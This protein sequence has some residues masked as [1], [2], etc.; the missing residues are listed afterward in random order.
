[1][2]PTDLTVGQLIDIFINR[3]PIPDDAKHLAALE[4]ALDAAR[5]SLAGG[6]YY[7]GRVSRDDTKIRNYAVRLLLDALEGQSTRISLFLLGR[8]TAVSDA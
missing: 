3:V 2:T 7:S 6:T 5:W 1:M 8:D 4:E